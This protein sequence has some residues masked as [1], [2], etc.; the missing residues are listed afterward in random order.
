[1]NLKAVG[2]DTVAKVTLQC[3]E[4]QRLIVSILAGVFQFLDPFSHAQ[5]VVGT[6]K[7]YDQLINLVLDDTVE[8][9]RGKLLFRSLT[10]LC[11]CF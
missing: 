4:Q 2:V 10:A 8:Y 1:M 11:Q 7:G 9:L 6:L 5:T 3:Q